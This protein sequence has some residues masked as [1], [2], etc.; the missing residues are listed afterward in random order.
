M[1][2]IVGITTYAERAR[3]GAWDT[4]T[5]L[6]PLAYVE[7]IE[8]AGGRPLLVP[9]VADAVEE[10]LDALDGI[11]FSG[12]GD[13]DP[14]TYGADAHPETAG[15]RPNRDTA[16]LAL[17]AAALHLDLPTLAVC[18]GFEIMN[19]ARGGDLV[20]HLPDLVG[21]QRHRHTPG[22]YADH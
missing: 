13:V 17:M 19:V 15:I 18:R 3:W 22:V 7:A 4:P 16:E 21:D 14:A 10:T 6:V 2:P 12:G 5:A 9:P 20:Q 8:R 1:R 11:V